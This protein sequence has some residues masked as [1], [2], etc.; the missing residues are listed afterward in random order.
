MAKPV[1]W[2]KPAVFAGSL[3]PLGELSY[4]WAT[5]TLGANP[6]SEALNR[7]GLTTLVFLT[8]TLACTP[9][10]LA[11]GWTW[12]VRIRRMLGL[13]AFFYGSLHFAIYALL[14]QAL[15]LHA[16]LADIVKR[17]FILV[18]FLALLLMAPLAVTST[19]AMVRR[20]GF[21]RW[22]RLHRLVYAAGVLGAV[23]FI[24]RVKRDVTE[25]AL[26]AGVLAL[27]LGMRLWEAGRK[28]WR[29]GRTVQETGSGAGP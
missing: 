22:K 12:P 18:G 13:F 20:L 28:A 26:Y 11:L 17:N 3:A 29:R 15:D 23:H 10:K 24:W 14:D 2:L 9:L 4:R 16:V 5:G 7:M 25:P 6:I 8:G 21:P 27:L 1:P 19:D